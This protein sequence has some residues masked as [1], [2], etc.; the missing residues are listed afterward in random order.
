MTNATRSDE[1]N[2]E[3]ERQDNQ[4][5]YDSASFT[6]FPTAHRMHS[7]FLTRQRIVY[8]RGGGNAARDTRTLVVSR[9]FDWRHRRADSDGFG[10]SPGNRREKRVRGLTAGAVEHF[11]A[12]QPTD[13][14]GRNRHQPAEEATIPAD[15][16]CGAEAAQERPLGVN[17][18]LSHRRKRK[19]E[20][21]GNWR[22]P[23][24]KRIKPVKCKH[25]SYRFE[26][27]HAWTGQ[28]SW[29]FGESR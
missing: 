12:M 28:R 13:W 26:N 18:A 5:R 9:S 8:F 11:L 2:D 14:V 10:G 20:P 6:L 7:V 17:D 15:I 19:E 3:D 22:G 27:S 24:W 25:I 16:P 21:P 1:R 4:V 29:L 23:A